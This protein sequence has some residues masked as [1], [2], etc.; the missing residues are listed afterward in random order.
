[1]MQDTSVK[2]LPSVVYMYALLKQISIPKINQCSLNQARFKGKEYV[3]T[4]PIDGYMT[5]LSVKN[6][7]QA[8]Y[9][10]LCIGDA[11]KAEFDRHASENNVAG[12]PGQRNSI[13]LSLQTLNVF[14]E[15]YFN[16]KESI[17]GE[18]CP[19]LTS[20]SRCVPHSYFIATPL[21]PCGDVDAEIKKFTGN[22]SVGD[23]SD[24]L[25]KAIHAFAHFSVVYS[26]NNIVF[27]DLQGMTILL[28]RNFNADSRSN[29]QGAPDVNG[30]MCL[31]DPQAHTYVFQVYSFKFDSYLSPRSQSQQKQ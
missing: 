23:A 12:I 5:P 13:D 18:L 26:Q 24:H 29:V 17:F 8:E 10:L 9:A 4:Q 16:F 2:D 7:L 30:R 1:M 25:T 6:V 11:F 19:T 3:L 22:G 31:I 21:L 28:K 20:G 14:L 27:C 15:F